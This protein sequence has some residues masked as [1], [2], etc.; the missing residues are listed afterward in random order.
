MEMDEKEEPTWYEVVGPDQEISQ[1]DI[2]LNCPIFIPNEKFY[3]GN[4]EEGHLRSLK[5]EMYYINAIIMT[6]ACDLTSEDGR[7][8]AETVIVARIDSFKGE[9]KT[10][11]HDANA[12]RKPDLQVLKGHFE[13]PIQMDYQL[14]DF[15][16]IYSSPYRLLDAVSKRQGARLR[17]Q[18]PY[19]EYLS[20]RFGNYFSRVGLPKGISKDEITREWGRLNS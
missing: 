11:L 13:D 7:T 4:L 12:G 1:G 3:F 19:L 8:P 15:T 6:Q 9:S 20:Q 16:S 10:L 18:S 2:L 14:V 17:L 5:F